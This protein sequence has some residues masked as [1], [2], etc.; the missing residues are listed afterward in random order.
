MTHTNNENDR[1]RS[2]RTN[3][4]VK[5]A[6]ATLGLTRAEYLRRHGWSRA[7]AESAIAAREVR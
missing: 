6:A 3:Q 1:A 4:L 7:A 2:A 5:D